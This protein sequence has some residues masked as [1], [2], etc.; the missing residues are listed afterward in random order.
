MMIGPIL[1]PDPLV[2]RA[3]DAMLSA[4]GSLGI[5]TLAPDRRDEAAAHLA[6]VFDVNP[7]VAR[8]RVDEL[9]PASPEGQLSL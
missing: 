9:Y 6:N 7:A 8:I 5:R 2:R 1:L 4:G 3:I